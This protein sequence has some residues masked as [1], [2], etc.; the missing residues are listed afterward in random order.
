MI[1]QIKA[2]LKF[3]LRSTNQHG[4]HSPFV[5]NLVTKCFYDKKKIK[6]FRKIKEFNRRLKRISYKI[7]V[8]DFG[9]G[10]RVTKNNK[11]SV[12][13]IAKNSGTTFKRAIL[14]YKLVKYFD[15]NNLL[16]EVI[17]ETTFSK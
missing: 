12:S 16:F 7:D 3:L 10:S 15:E 13:S 9:A 4:V 11:R 5:Y 1:Y 17:Q 8:T 2:Y 6:E 14:L